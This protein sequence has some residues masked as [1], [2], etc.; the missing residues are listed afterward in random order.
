MDNTNNGKRNCSLCKRTVPDDARFCP[1][2]GM[3]LQDRRSVPVSADAAGTGN[4]P[5]EQTYPR[6]HAVSRCRVCFADIPGDAASCPACGTPRQTDADALVKHIQQQ[7]NHIQQQSLSNNQKPIQQHKAAMMV[8]APRE[9]MGNRRPSGGIHV[10]RP[11]AEK[12]PRICPVCHAEVSG[13]ADHCP[14]CLAALPVR[15]P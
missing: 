3:V 11:E 9:F 14:V 12:T 8:Y 15:K 6:I 4:V 1:Y 10:S 7:I 2:C 13:D 5:A